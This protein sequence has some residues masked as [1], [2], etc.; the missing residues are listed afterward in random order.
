MFESVVA[1]VTILKPS[2]QEAARPESLGSQD[3]AFSQPLS[4]QGVD[5][6]LELDLPRTPSTLSYM[7]YRGGIHM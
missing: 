5:S 3:L 2:I 4:V 1:A 6:W 7:L